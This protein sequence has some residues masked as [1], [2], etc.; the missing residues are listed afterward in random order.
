MQS[1]SNGSDPSSNS[2][3]SSSTPTS[4]IESAGKQS[5]LSGQLVQDKSLQQRLLALS[6][7]RESVSLNASV[8]SHGANLALG[9]TRS[10]FDEAKIVKDSA[11][12][13]RHGSLS[14]RQS[15]KV[16]PLKHPDS[17]RPVVDSICKD[18]NEPSAYLL[19]YIAK[20][21]AALD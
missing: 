13:P 16:K 19:D 15:E 9:L 20:Q 11:Q 14:R 6:D 5:K 17:E 12:G 3:K 4:K 8:N 18:R 2:Q 7:H 1:D 21:R 10:A